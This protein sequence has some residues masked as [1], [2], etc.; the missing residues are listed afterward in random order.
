[1]NDIIEE[2][3]VENERLRKEII[4][5]KDMIKSLKIQISE[6]KSDIIVQKA[7]QRGRP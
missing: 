7:E 3:A 5:L 1:M 6:I 4:M 2:L